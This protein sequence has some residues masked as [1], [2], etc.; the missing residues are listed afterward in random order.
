[1]IA[2][3]KTS[4]A[5]A[6]APR[7]APQS[8]RDEETQMRRSDAASSSAT[9]TYADAARAVPANV[10][11]AQPFQVNGA[12]DG[13]VICSRCRTTNA[14]G[15]DRCVSCQA[16]MR[17]NRSAVETGL[18]RRQQPIELRREVDAIVAGIVADKGGESECSTLLKSYIR[19]LGEVV[20]MLRLLVNDIAA[21]GLLSPS[22]APRRVLDA[23]FAGVDRFDRL[24]TRIGVKREARPLRSNLT[25]FVQK[26]S[27]HG[28]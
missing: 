20:L 14:A 13:S 8:A 12:G 28:R 22:H 19:E 11:A 3:P 26:G 17:G 24:A 27:G 23:Y 1:M 18:Y 7:T 25:E 5:E 16:F 2:E 6:E 15:V 21:H 9:A 10:P 4:P